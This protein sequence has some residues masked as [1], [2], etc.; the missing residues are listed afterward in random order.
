M[1]NEKAVVKRSAPGTFFALIK[2]VFTDAPVLFTAASLAVSIVHG[3]SFAVTT[4]MMQR[5]FDAV[6][7]TAEAGNGVSKVVLAAILLAL[8]VVLTQV[9][10]GLHNFMWS[11]YCTLVGGNLSCRINR[12]AASL[13]PVLF[14]NLDTLN[15]INQAD[16]GAHKTIDILTAPLSLIT[17]YTPYFAFMFVY[18][19]L[20]EPLLAISLLL[21]IVP[22][23]LSQLVRHFAFAQLEDK[24]AHLRRENEYWR[25]CVGNKETRLLGAFGYFRSLFSQS[26]QLLNVATWRAEKKSGLAELA[27]QTLTL[28]GYISVI[29]LFVDALLKGRISVGAFAAVF[30]S[31][32]LMFAIMQEMVCNKFGNFARSFGPARNFMRFLDLPERGGVCQTKDNR[33]IRLKNV[34]FR[35]PNAAVDSLQNVNF[36]IAR[37]EI[38]A[39]V[40]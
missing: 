20:L 19:Y 25:T 33:G 36:E 17:F 31:I 30:A 8:T 22:I 6:A 10:N 14:E 27:M 34:S 40:G 38:I 21:I 26:L 9:L 7:Q 16:E 28:C 2:I 39:V 15:L 11:S 35:Y 24:I 13:A 23:A 18:L 32:D 29:W 4:P 37:G 12:K 1:E 3:L 5:L